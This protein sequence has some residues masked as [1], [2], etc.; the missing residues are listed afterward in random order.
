MSAPLRGCGERVGG[1]GGTVRMR[2]TAALPR[3]RERLPFFGH[4]GALEVIG[5]VDKH[6]LVG[7]GEV[8]DSIGMFFS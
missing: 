2:P 8:E 3:S 5:E 4:E 6:D 7:R 1:V